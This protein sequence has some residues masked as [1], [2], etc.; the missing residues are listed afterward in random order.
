M[1]ATIHLRV[2][3][4]PYV[5]GVAEATMAHGD[6][7]AAAAL[8]AMLAFLIELLARLIGDDMAMKLIE[9]S[10]VESSQGKEASDDM[11]EKA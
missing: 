10:L 1:L 8:E 7:A 5:Q 3:S 9:R 4:E 11:R 2:R 6:A